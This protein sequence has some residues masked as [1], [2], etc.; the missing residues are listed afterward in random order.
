M[1]WWN[2]SV[3]KQLVPQ[4]LGLGF[5]LQQSFKIIMARTCNPIVKEVEFGGMQWLIGQPVYPTL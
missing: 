5:Y 3:G 4:A 2:G 1:D